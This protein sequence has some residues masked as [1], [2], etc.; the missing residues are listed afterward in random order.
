M[1]TVYNNIDQKD[2]IFGISTFDMVVLLAF[3]SLVSNLGVFQHGVMKLFSFFLVLMVYLLLWAFKK[4]FSPNYFQHM[5]I[6]L[7]TKKI[8]IAGRHE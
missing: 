2:S 4:R 7:F 5:V 8:L 3:Y 6:F 1:H